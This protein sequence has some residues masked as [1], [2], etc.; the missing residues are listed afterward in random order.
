LTATFVG[1]PPI[2]WGLL[3]L[4]IVAFFF[5]II[6][7]IIMYILV[8]RRVIRF[9]NIVVTANPIDAGTEVVINHPKTAGK[10]VARFV[11]LLPSVPAS[12]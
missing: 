5:F 4:T 8:V 7:G 10:I 2:P 3:F 11:S 6:P 1:R 9:Q 12:A